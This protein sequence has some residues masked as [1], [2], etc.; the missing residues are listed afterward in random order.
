MDKN[1]FYNPNKMLSYNRIL[2]FVI[3]ARGI[4]KT[5]GMKKYVIN[6]FLKHGKQ[7]LWLR[8]YKDEL[9]SI[10]RWFNDIRDEFPGHEFKVKGRQFFVDGKLAGFAHPLS[11]WQSLKSDAFPD[12]E[13]IL[14]DEALREKDNSGYIPNEPQ[15]LLN[16][17]DTVF[18]LRDNVRCI[19]MSNA[20]T[21]V[22]PFFL[23]FNIVPD[24]KKRYNAYNS[25]VVEIP[26]SIDFSIERRKT[27]FG[28]L[29]DG[30]EYGDMSLDNDFVND[31]S[32][33]IEKR[34]PDSK[35]IFAVVYKGM[36]M[37]VWLDQQKGLLYM[38]TSYD[39]STKKIYALT[40][41]DLQE[42]IMLLNNWKNNY[43]LYK[44][45][46]AFKKGYLRFDN[47]VMRNVG[48][49]MFKRMN[50]Q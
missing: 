9:K 45:V 14:Y 13:T 34:S 17:M 33:F 12:L 16:V 49:E 38:D 50:I 30:T 41:D 8:R 27:K 29:I 23:Y 19:C 11:A 10:P 15:A 48:Y 35:F 28:Q 37:G 5:Y 26:D 47:Q 43:H 22:N 18:R 31:S 39:P 32:V 3:G 6:R 44:L 24:I 42:N 21:I 2:N 40:T 46:S 36:T 1:M 25:V 20:V 4:G 7:F